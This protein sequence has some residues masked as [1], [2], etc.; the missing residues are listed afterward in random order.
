MTGNPRRC[1]YNQFGR[2]FNLLSE[3][4]NHRLESYTCQC[5]RCAI[6]WGMGITF[7]ET[8][9]ISGYSNIPERLALVLTF[10]RGLMHWVWQINTR[11]GPIQKLVVN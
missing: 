4:V 9:L 5:Q 11:C 1:L 7:P 10:A 6:L 3:L 8:D 2:K